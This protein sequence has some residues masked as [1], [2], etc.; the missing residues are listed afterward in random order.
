MQNFTHQ[1]SVISIVI[2]N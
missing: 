1:V 2:T